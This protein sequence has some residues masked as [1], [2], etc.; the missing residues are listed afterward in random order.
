MDHIETRESDRD[1]QAG[2]ERAG[3]WQSFGVLES[4]CAQPFSFTLDLCQGS[5]E[6][7]WGP[8]QGVQNKLTFAFLHDNRSMS[9]TRGND[10]QA[11]RVA[12]TSKG[13][14]TNEE[15]LKA[16]RAAVLIPWLDA[17]VDSRTKD[18][19]V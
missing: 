9:L 7:G 4:L 3:G 11:V 5:R 12:P 2:D 15:V 13:G 1:R 18:V 14:H 17:V 8:R 19:P 16:S 10:L 6:R